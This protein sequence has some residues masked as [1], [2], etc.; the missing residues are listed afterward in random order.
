MTEPRGPDGTSTGGGTGG[1]TVAPEERIA[2][3]V[4]ALRSGHLLVH[5]TASVYGIGAVARELD[6]EIAR[7]K[8]RAADHPLLRIADSLETLRR[9][10]PS[11]RW[12]EEAEALAAAVWPGPLTL[13][14]D[15]GS[16]EGLGVRVEGHEL[17]RRVLRELDGTMSS[18]SLNRT[19][20]SPAQSEEDVRRILGAMPAPRVPVRQLLAGDLP[21]PPPSTVLSLRGGRPTVL[22]EGAV[23][24]ERIAE[25]LGREP[26]RV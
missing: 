8:G 17:T 2:D 26:A 3:A 13:V 16:G 15:D 1:S 14:L 6:A 18:T 25:L 11:L 21:G 7:L 19:G 24:L 5:P 22:R 12:S 4:E 23:A 10:H 20:E 9:E